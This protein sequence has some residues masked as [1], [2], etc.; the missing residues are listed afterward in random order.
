M[1]AQINISLPLNVD[2]SGDNENIVIHYKDGNLEVVGVGDDFWDALND[3]RI[4]F[5]SKIHTIANSWQLGW[6]DCDFTCLAN[7][8]HITSKVVI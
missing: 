4:E 2:I 8:P 7:K 6:R 3:F 1:K 5:A